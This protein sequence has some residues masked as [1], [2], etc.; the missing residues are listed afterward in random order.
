MTVLPDSCRA[1]VFHAPGQPLALERFPLPLPEAGECLVRIR[2]ATICGSDLHS[3]FGR[4]HSPAP[5]VLGHEM[6]GL[7][8]GLGTGGVRDFR[9]RPLAVGD[10]VTWSMVWSCGQ[11]YYC[12]HGLRVKCERLLKFGHEAIA[13]GRALMGGMAEYCHLPPGTSIFR[14]PDNLPDEVASPANCATA[15]VAA[16]FRQAGPCTGRSLIVHGAGMLGLT[17]CAM[18]AVQHASQVIVLEPD[19]QRRAQALRF[20][21][22]T[23]LDSRLPAREIERQIRGLMDQRGADIG[24]ELSGQPE[25]VELGLALLRFGGRFVMAG[26][27][28]TARPVQLSAEQIVRRL[29]HVVGVYNYAPEDLETALTFLAAVQDRFPFCGLVGPQFTLEDVQAAFEYAEHQRP[30]RVAVRPSTSGFPA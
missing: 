21:A 22:T 6:V 1:A 29:L 15:T 12:R 3:Y 26:A 28:F 19:P 9:G 5:S 13:P 23:T 2:C 8:A 30:P 25:A 18:A 17:A 10:R 14:V 11:C 20:G 27:T 7:V 16:V 24:L 4:R